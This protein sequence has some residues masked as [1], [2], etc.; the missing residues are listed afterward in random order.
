VRRDCSVVSVADRVCIECVEGPELY[1]LTPEEVE[2]VEKHLAG[3]GSFVD[4]IVWGI[5]WL[6]ALNACD[7]EDDLEDAEAKACADRLMREYARS[8]RIMRAGDGLL[9]LLGDYVFTSWML[10]DYPSSGC[11]EVLW[12]GPQVDLCIEV[13][14]LPEGGFKSFREIVEY[15]RV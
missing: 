12:L 1:T 5:S 13:V 10:I 15:F 4:V 9:Y 2:F 6:E 11:L 3:R 14:F 7:P 8:F